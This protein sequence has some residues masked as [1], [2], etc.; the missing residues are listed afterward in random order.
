MDPSKRTK[1][2]VSFVIPYSFG[3]DEDIAQKLLTTVLKLAKGNMKMSQNTPSKDLDEF[4]EKVGT[5]TSPNWR[6][7]WK[8]SKTMDEEYGDG[9]NHICC[10]K[11]G[12]C[13]TCGDCGTFGCGRT[14]PLSEVVKVSG[15]ARSCPPP[16]PSGD[17]WND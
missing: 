3:L 6:H 17:Y 7:T 16:W 13:L 10:E 12:Y 8:G 2:S 5:D 4:F 1:C 11:C 14:K 15:S 9:S